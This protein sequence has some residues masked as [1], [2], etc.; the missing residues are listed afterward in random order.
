M[1][2]AELENVLDLLNSQYQTIKITVEEEQH[3]KLSFLDVCIEHRVP[4]TN[5]KQPLHKS[6]IFPSFST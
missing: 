3:G 1:K 6:V 4:Q 5:S 2:N